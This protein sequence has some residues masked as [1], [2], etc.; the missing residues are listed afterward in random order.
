MESRAHALAAGLF[1]IVL[2]AGVVFGLWY[3][4]SGDESGRD[5]LLVTTADV[6]GLNPQAQVR[7]RGIRAGKVSSI[8]INPANPRE[9][10]VRISLPE[11][12]PVTQSMRAELG[13]L[14]VTGLALVELSDDGS[15]TTLLKPG[16]DGEVR[17]PMRG[18]AFGTLGSNMNDTM[19]ALR[20]VLARL[21]VLLDDE[22]AAHISATVRNLASATGH[23]D[24]TLGALP[25]LTQDLQLT[26]QR[27]QAVLSDD[28]IHRASEILSRLES[29]A[30]A[31]EPL[32]SEL[33]LSLA[34]IRALSSELEKLSRHTGRELSAETLPR[35]N[36][37]ID[38]A[39]RDSR[40]LRRMLDDVD[41]SPQMFLLGRDAVSPGPGESGFEAPGEGGVKP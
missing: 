30:A 31:G 16:D 15:D 3:L 14:G 8:G 26:L 32:A 7:Y 1:L 36:R 18:S 20:N 37:L 4:S 28:N 39:V 27:I 41:S 25:G 34:S 24:R 22:N 40:R 35:L 10:H 21:H 5:Y 11:R 17:I 33:R 29:L 13:Y 19:D 6:G 9:I 23:L 38:E 2:G 12:F